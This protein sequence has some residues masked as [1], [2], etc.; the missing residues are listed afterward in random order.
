MKK[1]LLLLI[2][3]AL[4]QTTDGQNT[5]RNQVRDTITVHHNPPRH[6]HN[7]DKAQN[8]KQTDTARGKLHREKNG[9]NVLR[10]QPDKK[11]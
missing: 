10:P 9:G 11:P 2:C 3:A 5:K 4:Y 7:K 1:L 8:K 6:R